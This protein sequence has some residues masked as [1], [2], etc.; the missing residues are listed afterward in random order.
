MLCILSLM[1]ALALFC[2]P[3]L[4]AV[5][6]LQE[7]SRL[8]DNV[9]GASNLALI[10]VLSIVTVLIVVVEAMRLLDGKM[11]IKELL[12]IMFAVFILIA[13]MGFI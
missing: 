1:I 13:V 2:T 3:V 11:D 7:S 10:A 6:E 12:S 4:G 9:E 8:S 5:S